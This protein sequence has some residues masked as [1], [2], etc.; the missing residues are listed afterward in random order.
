MSQRL[1]TDIS[2]PLSTT[3]GRMAAVRLKNANVQIFRALLSLASANLLVRVMGMFNQVIVT[4][5]FGQGSAMDA[6]FVA[7]ALPTLLAQLMASS[8]EASVIPVYANMRSKGTKEQISRLFSTLLNLLIILVTLFTI[9]MFFLRQQLVTLSAPWLNYHTQHLAIGLTPYIIPVLIFMTLN[10]FMDCLLNAE[11]QFG[12]PAYAGILVPFTTAI[13]VLLAGQSQGVVM[14]CIGTLVGQVLQLIV[15]IIR[16]YHAKF[17]YRFVLDLSS[18][19]IRAIGIVAWP[20]LFTGL[21]GQASPFVDQIFSS[22][23]NAGSIAVLNN[24]LKLISVPVG[25]IFSSTA[26]AALPYL[27]RQAAIKDMKAFKETL[28]LYMWAVGIA[29]LALSI[30]L[31]LLAHTV[32]QILFQHGTF[33][34]EDTTRTTI[35]FIGFAIGLTPM[36]LGFIA[37]RAFSALGKTK[38]LMYVTIFSVTANAIFDTI[39]GRLW[40]SFGIAFATS[41]VYL[42]TMFILLFTLRNMI[43][44]LSLFTPPREVL[45]VI[46]KLGLGHDY[47]QWVTWKE[48]NLS[49]LRISY[50]FIRRM[51]RIS[52]ILAV[53]AAGIAGSILNALVMLRLAFGSII[54]LYLLRYRYALLI[55]WVLLDAFIGSTLPIFNGQNFLSGLTLPSLLVLFA[56]PT[57]EALKRMPALAFLLV[58]LVWVFVGIGIAP[59]PLTTFLTQ[60]AIALDSIAVGVLTISVLTTRKRMLRIIDAILLPSIFIALYGIYGY[61]TKQ[62]GVLDGTTS[63]FRIGS[64]FGDI[65]PTLALFL[66]IIIPLSIY[67]TF[68]LQG[69]QRAVG[70]LIVLLLLVAL[71]LTFTRAALLSVPVSILIMILCLPSRKLK[72]GVLAGMIAVTGLVALAATIGNTSIFSRF[73]NPD[74]L[75]LNGRTYLWSAVIDHFDPTQLLGNGLNASEILLTRLQV[76]V[77]LGVI[78]TATHNVFLETLYDQGIIGFTLLVLMFISI[79]VKLLTKMRTATPDHRLLLGMAVAIFFNVI[80]QSLESN[81]FWNSSI[82]IYFWIIMALPFAFCWAPSK[83]ASTIDG[84]FIEKQPALRLDIVHKKGRRHVYKTTSAHA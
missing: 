51:T 10:S 52:I 32:I 22:S 29:T 49:D 60:W 77:G 13:L 25:V 59:I 64:V 44:K 7:A 14:L 73:L 34:T 3:N 37:S 69:F 28:R 68:T 48:Q 26:R 6:Y 76:G 79:V 38:V 71:G 55:V 70:L 18:P 24:A 23:F 81:D 75:T 5:R 17:V 20:A 53:F 31:I 63:L 66:S 65:P 11:G 36:A 58:Y 42:C 8:L 46:W 27:A 40:Q 74:V 4:A 61:F 12:W 21:I 41:V 83:Q 72:M 9:G 15:I 2:Q 47:I 39:F 78:A 62:N 67:R 43:G 1:G 19:E 82:N 56:L 35:T 16:A 54:V 33:T 57:Q 84:N 50:D 30:A 80:V 45:S